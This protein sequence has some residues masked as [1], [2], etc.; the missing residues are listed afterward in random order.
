LMS[1]NEQLDI[2]GELAAPGLDEQ[3]ENGREGEMGERGTSAD[4]PR[5]EHATA[6]ITNLGFETP[7]AREIEHQGHG[8]S[9]Q[10][11]QGAHGALIPAQWVAG[12]A[13]A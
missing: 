10:D 7:Q 1:Q 2:F 13:N 8:L 4:A 3:P 6:E 12:A 11:R 5:L 9:I